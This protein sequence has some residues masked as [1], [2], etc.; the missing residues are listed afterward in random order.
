ML[1]KYL[2]WI[3]TVCLP[4]G[5]NKYGVF[6]RWFLPHVGYMSLNV[7]KCTLCRASRGVGPISAGCSV[8]GK[9]FYMCAVKWIDC[10][11]VQI[12]SGGQF[13]RRM[14]AQADFF[15]GQFSCLGLCKFCGPSEGMSCPQKKDLRLHSC[16]NSQLLV[17]SIISI[18]YQL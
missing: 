10:V 13:S 14:N 2:G 1:S 7:R 17:I 9:G 12:V 16:L 15:Y 6:C 5:M 18:M 8:Y 4:I 11:D 3:N